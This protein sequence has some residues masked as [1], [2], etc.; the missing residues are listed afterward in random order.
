MLDTKN[1]TE[2][3]KDIFLYKNFLNEEESFKLFQLAKNID[4]AKWINHNGFHYT[5]NHI[6]EIKFVIDRL[7]YK[8]SGDII[9]DDSCYFQ[10]YEHGQGMGVH[11]D[12]NKVLE[13]I[14]LSKKYIDGMNFKIVRQ[15]IYG[16]VI[17]LNSVDGGEI[18]YPYQEINYS[19]S[20]GD[21][22]IHSAKGHCMHGVNK[23]NSDIRVC[24][25]TYIY[26]E[27]KVPIL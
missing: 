25:P 20:P 12:D 18:Y 9:L 27:I 8:V 14:E 3:G 19:P 15:P 6:P 11:R 13:D 2:I 16:V 7:K 17:Y 23:L 5:S 21:L 1:A 26:K 24:I 22:I 4:K 10:M